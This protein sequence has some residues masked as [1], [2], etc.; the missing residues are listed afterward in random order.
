MAKKAYIGVD[1]V[2]RETK[3]IYL[4]IDNVA[5][6]IKKTYIGDENSLARLWYQDEPEIPA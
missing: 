1:G 6:K 2:A 5:R 4:G 3:S